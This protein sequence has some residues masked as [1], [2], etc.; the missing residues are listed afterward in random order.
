MRK[1]GQA[2]VHVD[3]PD[4]IWEPIIIDDGYAVQIRLT[5]AA[6]AVM[7][8]VVKKQGP[9]PSDTARW[10][11]FYAAW[12]DQ[13]MPKSEEERRLGRYR[14]RG[15]G[16]EKMFLRARLSNRAQ[17]Y[18]NLLFHHTRTGRKSLESFARI[19]ARRHPHFPHLST[20]TRFYRRYVLDDEK[21]GLIG[22]E[23]ISAQLW[24]LSL[25]D[26]LQQFPDCGRDLA[27]LRRDD[28]PPSK[29]RAKRR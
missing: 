28:P 2:R 8:H 9:F 18:D 19:A 13:F 1:P 15:L 12:Y 20:G 7:K 3:P 11:A 29:G 26:F 10:Q 27:E 14:L 5:R 22:S 4:A 17:Y 6:R 24:R 23:R 16:K 25:D 21:D